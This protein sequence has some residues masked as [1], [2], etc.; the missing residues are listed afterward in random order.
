MYKDLTGALDR[1][2][3]VHY[4]VYGTAI[5]AL[6]HRGF[7]PWDDDLDIAVWE[8]DLPAIEEAVKSE[9]DPSK[10]FY[11][12][13]LGD[14]H[15]HLV[16]RGPGFEL[17]LR[18]GTAP[19]IDIFPIIRYPQGRARRFFAFFAAWGIHITLTTLDLMGSLRGYRA[20][21]TA[22]D[23]LKRVLSM[24]PEPNTDCTAVLTTKFHSELFPRGWYGEPRRIPF[25]DTET[26]IPA[27]AD[28]MLT[29]EFGDYMTPPLEDQRTG[30]RG[31]PL[32]IYKDY[33][34]E[35]KPEGR[36]KTRGRIIEVQL[37]AHPGDE[38]P[39]DPGRDTR[40]PDLAAY[41]RQQ[42]LAR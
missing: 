38:G 9:L 1:H 15:P 13:P 32:N 8:E 10:Y 28:R 37:P 30:C 33:L 25:E 19:F 7:I 6:R 16:Y 23:S 17:A 35:A 22:P 12:R 20:M 41:I 31:F 5:G 36:R 18:N 11:H 24:L 39:H 26:P 27:E 40:A 4:A 34:L 29:T 2:G 3:I 14:T 42:L 21:L